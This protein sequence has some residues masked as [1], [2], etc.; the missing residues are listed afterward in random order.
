VKDLIGEPIPCSPG[1][2]VVFR[3]NPVHQAALPGEWCLMPGDAHPYVVCPR[4]SRAG[5]LD[6]AHSVSEDG[7]VSPSIVCAMQSCGDGVRRC[8][9][10]YYGKLDDYAARRAR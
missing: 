7:V 4:C 5:R 1:E 6:S 10:H 2:R 8:D 9:A 3:F